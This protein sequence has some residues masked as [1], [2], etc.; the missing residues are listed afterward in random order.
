VGAVAVS[1][2]RPSLIRVIGLCCYAAPAVRTVWLNATLAPDLHGTPILS[3]A[4]LILCP[5]SLLAL[6]FLGMDL[7]Q[8]AREPARDW[9]TWATIGCEVIGL[10]G[11]LGVMIG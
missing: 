3:F 10:G 6:V 7:R 2:G 1:T 9:R 4:L 5:V 11:T 8:L